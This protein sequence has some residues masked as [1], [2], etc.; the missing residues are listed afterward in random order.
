MPVHKSLASS[1]WHHMPLSEQ[2]GNIG[3]EF[4]RVLQWRGRDDEHFAKASARLFELIDLTL[5]DKRWHG[6]L[7]ELVRMRELVGDISSGSAYYANSEQ[8]L[9]DYFLHFA[10]RARAQH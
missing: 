6:R 5:A 8:V 1:R 4:Q 7:K 3:S 2:L 9:S 10:L